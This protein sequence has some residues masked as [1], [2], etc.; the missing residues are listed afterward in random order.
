MFGCACRPHHKAIA[1]IR[2]LGATNLVVHVWRIGCKRQLPI[3]SFRAEAPVRRFVVAAAFMRAESFVALPS[4]VG[5]PT[6]RG[7]A[8]PLI[9]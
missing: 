5:N 9:L 8:A 2:L 7:R 3:L 6:S 4:L 1:A